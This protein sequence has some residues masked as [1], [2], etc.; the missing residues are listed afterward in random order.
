MTSIAK[1]LD[2]HRVDAKV[3][4]DW[5][6]TGFGGSD[7][8]SYLVSEEEHETFLS[9]LNAHIFSRTPLRTSAL[10]ERHRDFGGPPLVDHDM[11]YDTGG[12]LVRRFTPDHIQL[13]IAEYIAAMI[14]FSEA[15]TLTRDLDFYHLEKPGPE[16]DTS[17]HKDGVHIQCPTLTTTFEYQFCIRGF[18]LTRDIIPKVFGDT[19][20]TNAP[21]DVYDVS[22]I[23]KNNWFL[24]GAS[25]PNKQPYKVARIWR[26][27]I[28]QIRELLETGMPDYETLVEEIRTRMTSIAIPTNTLDLMKTLSIRLHH[29]AVD[30]LPIREDRAAEWRTLITA[31]GQGKKEAR[32]VVSHVGSAAT[33]AKKAGIVSEKQLVVT[34]EGA[35][36][37]RVTNTKTPED[38]ELA[39]RLCREC[40]NAPLRAGHYQEWVNTA[41]V[42]KNIADTEASRDAWI[43]LSRKATDA[44]GKPSMTD[45]EFY[46]KWDLIR[47]DGSKKLGMASL[48]H[49]AKEDNPDT[50]RSINSETHTQWIINYAKDTH[51]N[52]ASFIARLFQYEFRCS[53]GGRKGA[54]EWYHYATGSHA[55]KYMEL[56]FELRARLSG[57]VKNEYVV[58]GKKLSDKL[59]SSTD[60]SER[61][62]LDEKRK[63]LFAIERQLEMVGFKDNVMKE[64]TEKFYD[65]DFMKRLNSNGYLVGVGNG[66]L[67]LRCY[68]DETMTGRPHVR[69]RPGLAD[70]NIS[71]QMGRGGPA[72]DAINYEPYVADSPEQKLLAEFFEKIYPDPILRHYMLVLLASC[73]EGFNREQKFYVMSGPGGNGKSMI[74]KLMEFVFGEY[75]A[76]LSTTVF[77]RKRPDSGAANPDIITVKNRRYIHMGEPDDDEKINTAIMKQW[78]GGDQVS[79]RAMY[80]GQD[81]FVVSGKIFMSC[82]HLPAVS[83]MDGGTWRRLRVI[84]H[85]STFKDPGDPAINPSKHI[86]EKDLNLENKLVHWRTPFLG[87]L[88]HYYETHYIPE[89]LKEPDCVLAASNKYKEENDMFMSFFTDCYVKE[90]G[91]GPITVKA[92]RERFNDWKKSAGKCD[93]KLSQVYERMKE[94]CGSGSTEK[95]FWGVRETEEADLSGNLLRNMP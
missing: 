60:D 10:L 53:P 9:L 5:T 74:E 43:E 52:L 17:H 86:Y 93:L 35:D 73:L 19:G 37:F 92:V 67:D 50:F 34:E 8:G 90:A 11:K 45:A 36:T 12:S 3:E 88:V 47:V 59:V 49:W 66:V 33:V 18:L 4:L 65:S 80:E 48:V 13:F 6:L 56:P 84:P 1:F 55:W 87:L 46:K 75:G 15:E 94:A 14:Y 27:T 51:T 32:A 22:V 85:V 29:T 89:G 69:F 78:S 81:K 91:A 68:D 23:Q 57:S 95:E 25:K 77:T 26:L 63:K 83:K 38:I 41:I 7:K 72:M 70:D 54:V 61:E 39:Y 2:D 31:W 58:A 76:T 79:A 42:L 44:Q 64:C 24:Y 62:R 71:F 30:A 20:F 16:R 82:N 21:E 40:L 28:Q